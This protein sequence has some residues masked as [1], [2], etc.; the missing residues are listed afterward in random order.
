MGR[1]GPSA[2]RDRPNLIIRGEVAIKRF[3]FIPST[4]T[5]DARWFSYSV[6]SAHQYLPAR[7]NLGET[8]DLET[9]SIPLRSNTCNHIAQFRSNLLS[10]GGRSLRIASAR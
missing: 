5:P 9:I 10:P 4:Q 1:D 2:Q 6:T 7:P 8:S 3:H